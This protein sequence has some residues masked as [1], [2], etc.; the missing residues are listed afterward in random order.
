V[1]AVF[2]AIN[3]IDWFRPTHS[4]DI[5]HRYGLPFSFLS[6][7]GFVGMYKILWLGAAADLACIL[8]LAVVAGWAWKRFSVK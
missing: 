2:S 7:G 5:I 6:G 8:A 3:L 1:A 4:Y